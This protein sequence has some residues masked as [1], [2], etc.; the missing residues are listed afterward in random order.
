MLLVTM[1]LVVDRDPEKTNISAENATTTATM[2]ATTTG[3]CL[4]FFGFSTLTVM[5]AW[6]SLKSNRNS[7]DVSCDPQLIRA[8]DDDDNS[9]QSIQ[10]KWVSASA[11]RVLPA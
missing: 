10:I 5:F 7:Y 6:F 9:T 8:N 2:T 3:S 4:F 1:P 11:P